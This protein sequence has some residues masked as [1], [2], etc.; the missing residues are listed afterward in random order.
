MKACCSE[1]GTLLPM[2]NGIETFWFNQNTWD[3]ICVIQVAKFHGMQG[4]VLL[5]K[6]ATIWDW[7]MTVSPFC[8]TFC[9]YMYL[10]VHTQYPLNFSP[11]PGRIIAVL[12]HFYV[13]LLEHVMCRAWES[14]LGSTEKTGP[15]SE[16][17][18]LLWS[19]F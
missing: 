17:W 5:F 1:M 15:F 13:H 4:L 9:V 18:T 2:T 14:W 19:I 16:I 3:R 10:Y 8:L 12:L 6:V 11:L 7:K